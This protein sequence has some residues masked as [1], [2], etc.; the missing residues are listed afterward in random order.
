MCCR[1][2]ARRREAQGWNRRFPEQFWE[3]DNS[4]LILHGSYNFPAPTMSVP[5]VQHVHL[6]SGQAILFKKTHS[7][8][9][10]LS[11]II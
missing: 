3:N 10:I 9:K 7:F 8:N 4:L 6:F 1:T 2:E 11:P 5:P